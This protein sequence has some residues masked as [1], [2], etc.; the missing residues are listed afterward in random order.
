MANNLFS[1]NS[2]VVS[3]I[4]LSSSL[5]AFFNNPVYAYAVAEAAAV[6][7]APSPTPAVVVVTELVD[8]VCNRTSNYTSCVAALYSDP[9]TPDADRYTLAY[10]SFGLAYLNARK[11]LEH[12]TQLLKN[13]SS[14]SN[15][16]SQLQICQRDYKKGVVNLESALNDLNSETFFDLPRSANDT[17]TAAHDCQT[18]YPSFNIIDSMSLMFLCQICFVVS[19]LFTGPLLN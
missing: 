4:L 2:L 16:H 1:P 7:L 19:K 10:V 15:S 14:S 13:S 12:I 9:R 17:A 18:R 5:F 6:I 8:Q 11:T 3:I